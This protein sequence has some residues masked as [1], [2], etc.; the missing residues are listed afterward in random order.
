MLVYG[1]QSHQIIAQ[2]SAI[3]RLS[4]QRRGHILDRDQIRPDQQIAQSHSRAGSRPPCS[5]S[6]QIDWTGTSVISSTRPTSFCTNGS[7]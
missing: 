6:I 2:P 7:P 4:L 1:S 3:L 5:R